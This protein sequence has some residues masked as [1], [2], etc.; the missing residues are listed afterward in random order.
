MSKLKLEI[1][2]LRVKIAYA[3]ACVTFWGLVSEI[4]NRLSNAN[5]QGW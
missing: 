3:Q 4:I 2:I 1:M 5:G